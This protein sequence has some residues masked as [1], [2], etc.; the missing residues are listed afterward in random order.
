MQAETPHGWPT[1]NSTG[2]TSWNP[3]STCGCLNLD[4]KLENAVWGNIAL[5]SGLNR[6]PAIARTASLCWQSL[7]LAV[8]CTHRIGIEK[9]WASCTHTIRVSRS[10]LVLSVS[11]CQDKYREIFWHTCLPTATEVPSSSSSDATLTHL[12]L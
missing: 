2:T 1:W 11:A 10:A 4:A 12:S 6:L 8:K 5:F 9:C 7:A 3:S